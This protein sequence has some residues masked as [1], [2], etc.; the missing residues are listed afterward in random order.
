MLTGIGEDYI[1]IMTCCKHGLYQFLRFDVTL[2]YCYVD[3]LFVVIMCRVLE[4]VCFYCEMIA[5]IV[6]RLTPLTST[7]PHLNSDVGLEEGE[8]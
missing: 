8:Y 5:V 7:W 6:C 1:S 2:T 3:N 4:F